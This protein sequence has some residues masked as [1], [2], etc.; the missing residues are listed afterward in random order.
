MLFKKTLRRFFP[1]WSIGLAKKVLYWLILA[2][3]LFRC[4]YLVYIRRPTGDVFLCIS[5][6]SSVGGTELQVNLIA[7]FLIKSTL[8][9]IVITTG[10]IEAKSKHIFLLRLKEQKIVHISLGNLGRSKNRLVQLYVETLLKHLNGAI[11]H[12]FSPQSLLIARPAKRAGLKVI[13]TETC[14]P[15]K[16]PWWDPLLPNLPLIDYVVAVSKL[17]LE[18]FCKQFNYRG[19]S[20]VIYSVIEPLPLLSLPNNNLNTFHI[21][22]FGRIY[23]AKGVFVL[24][25]AFKEFALGCPEAKLTFFGDGPDKKALK[26]QSN[27]WNL[28]ERVFFHGFE[29]NRQLRTKIGAYD[30]F[31]LPS[32]TEGLPCSILEAM[33]A[34][35][36]ILATHV[37]GIP[38]TVEN[39]KTGI[40]VA[41][42]DPHAIAQALNRL[43]SEPNVR[44]SMGQEGY[45][46]YKRRFEQQN[47]LKEMVKLYENVPI[48]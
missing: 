14:L 13:Y 24:L 5:S 41:A 37:G 20:S 18:T 36:P 23:H 43:Y 22:Y 17:S 10:K 48:K 11:C 25:K 9:P 4:A 33:S 47:G 12:F 40:L 8:I 7:E 35:L 44:I 21:I 39:E 27:D 26:Q 32:Y 28:S 30:L 6:P 3:D 38:E 34:G 16:D 42:G 2:I 31:C 1:E 19:P 29:S 46:Q 45:R 15:A